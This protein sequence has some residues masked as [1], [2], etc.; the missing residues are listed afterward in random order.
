MIPFQEI[1]FFRL[2]QT[3]T[4]FETQ[5]DDWFTAIL[6][7]LFS[8]VSINVTIIKSVTEN[9]E[10]S[11]D[12]DS[13]QLWGGYSEDDMDGSIFIMD[14]DCGSTNLHLFDFISNRTSPIPGASLTCAS[15]SS[16]SSK[17]KNWEIALITL[18]VLTFLLITAIAVK[19]KCVG[20][21]ELN[22]SFL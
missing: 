1:F 15:S 22:E 16:S 3:D 10:K 17:L 14:Y 12:I 6:E 2:Y 19:N 5:A 8:Q 21:T 9:T 13:T 4:L 20:K 11:L 7:P 18:A